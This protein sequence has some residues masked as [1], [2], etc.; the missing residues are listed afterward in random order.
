M[1]DYLTSHARESSLEAS[2]LLG[3]IEFFRVDASRRLEK[4]RKSALGQFFTPAPVGRLMASMFET[5]A[6]TLNILDAGA[7]VGSL[8]A[9]SIAHICTQ[10]NPPDHIHVVAYEVDEMLITYLQE[11]V[12][13]CQS[14][15][16]KSNIVFTA[17]VLQKDFIVD[18]VELLGEAPP[19]QAGGFDSR[20]G[21]RVPHRTAVGP[22]RPQHVF[23]LPSFLV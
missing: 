7:G 21:R 16:E 23:S 20:R 14:V 8:F 13:L 2:A 1:V 11:T 19:A 4:D 12:H 5:S 17:E 15:C 9:A 6:S 3:T 10:D 22:F 18:C